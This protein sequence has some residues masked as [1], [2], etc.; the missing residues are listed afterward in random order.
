ML[1]SVFR[2]RLPEFLFEIVVE[3][4]YAVV[5]D[6]VGDFY[7]LFVCRTEQF[8]RVGEF[9]LV[10]ILQEAFAGV[11]FEEGSQARVAVGGLLGKFMHGVSEMVGRTQISDKVVQPVRVGRYVVDFL[12]Q[13]G[14]KQFV[15][16]DQRDCPVVFFWLH[17][18]RKTAFDG[19]F[20]HFVVDIER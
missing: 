14:Q 2:G 20:D 1:F 5:K 18:R 9:Q 6:L 15:D 19:I 12:F 16:D 17:L 13:K 11:G 8:L 7:N 10:D 4:T 3:R